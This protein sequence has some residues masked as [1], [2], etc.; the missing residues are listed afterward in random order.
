MSQLEKA[1]KS[2]YISPAS[3]ARFHAELGEREETLALLELALR[4]RDPGLLFIQTD[5]AFDSLHDDPR[6]VAIVK[7]VR[8]IPTV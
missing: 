8:L 1:A 7:R 4:K 6:Y 5:P 2:Q 3:I